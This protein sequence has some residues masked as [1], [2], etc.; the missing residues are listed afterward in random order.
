VNWKKQ[1]DKI[2]EIDSLNGKRRLS[3]FLS[4]YLFDALLN[5]GVD[6]KSGGVFGC[7]RQQI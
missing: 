1:P 7:R 3:Y 4:F 5:G 6:G 2:K